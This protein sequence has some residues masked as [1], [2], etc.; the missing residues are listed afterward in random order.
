MNELEALVLAKA[1]LHRNTDDPMTIEEIAEFA[2]E[3]H[4][5][6][7]HKMARLHTRKVKI[8]GSRAWGSGHVIQ[9]LKTYNGGRI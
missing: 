1:L 9:S 7:M 8:H 4:L 6:L 2:G 5:D 3:V